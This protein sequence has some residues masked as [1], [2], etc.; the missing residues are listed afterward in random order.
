MPRYA[1]QCS[2][3]E[4]TFDELFL[5]FS[6]AAE[7]EKEGLTCPKGCGKTAKRDTRPEKSMAGGAFRKYGL[8][9]YGGQS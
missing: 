1:Y 7:A 4:E 6:G 5:S 8:W 9:T 3:C 2:V